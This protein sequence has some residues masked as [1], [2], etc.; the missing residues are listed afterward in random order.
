[1]AIHCFGE[2]GN[3]LKC[4]CLTCQILTNICF[5]LFSSPS[6]HYHCAYSLTIML[7]TCVLA[8]SSVTLYEPNSFYG[9]FVVV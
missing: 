2:I 3:N 8:R 6:C 5:L 9:T 7:C 1:M 4:Y